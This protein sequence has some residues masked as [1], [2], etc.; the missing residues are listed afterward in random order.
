MRA[1][2]GLLQEESQLAPRPAL[3]EEHAKA[4]C[5][6]GP[7]PHA[8]DKH[9]G[10]RQVRQGPRKLQ[11]HV[12]AG[13][14][15]PIALRRVSEEPAV[16]RQLKVE[17]RLVEPLPDGPAQH[18]HGHENFADGR[19]GG[20]TPALAAREQKQLLRSLQPRVERSGARGLPPGFAEQMRDPSSGAEFRSRRITRRQPF[21]RRLLLDAGKIPRHG[22]GKREQVLDCGVGSG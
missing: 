10:L 17:E 4:G 19:I 1:D 13:H 9:I 14:H 7:H 15:R 5:H 12:P 2:F 18:R 21:R 22:R 16:G 3:L 6:I 20:Q 8:Q 11:E